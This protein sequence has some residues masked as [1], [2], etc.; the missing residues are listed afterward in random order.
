ME[1]RIGTFCASGEARTR[2][3]DQPKQMPVGSTNLF[4]FAPCLPTMVQNTTA[5]VYKY[6]YM[7]TDIFTGTLSC[8]SQ[9]QCLLLIHSWTS[10]IKLSA[11]PCL[12][13][14]FIWSQRHWTSLANNVDPWGQELRTCCWGQGPGWH[15]AW[16][17][18]H[19]WDRHELWQIGAIVILPPS[20][21]APAN[22]KL[23]SSVFT[24]YKAWVICSSPA[25]Q[26]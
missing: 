7:H 25:Y 9:R 23:S 21:R 3:T 2:D 15:H 10:P 1:F 11:F 13:Y 12:G 24:V 14:S 20:R 17:S 16:R 18:L 8:I 6:M 19:H 4:V 5:S 22:W 26:C